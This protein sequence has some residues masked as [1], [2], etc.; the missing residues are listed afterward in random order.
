[1]GTGAS[2]GLGAAIKTT[3]V[4]GIAQAISSLPV[5]ER[6]KLAEAIDM[7]REKAMD[8]ER[9][10]SQKEAPYLHQAFELLKNTFTAT[11][12][13]ALNDMSSMTE[14]DFTAKEEAT[15]KEYTEL[16]KKSFQHHDK[17]NTGTIEKN[18]AALFLSHL[19]AE[20]GG[21]VEALASVMCVNAIKMMSKVIDDIKENPDAPEEVKV[22]LE[23]Q[24]KQATDDAKKN[25]E[26]LRDDIAKQV[27]EYKASKGDRDQ[28]AFKLMDTNGDGTLNMKE[29]LT[30]VCP[31]T[32]EN[33]KLTKA[34]GLN[35]SPEG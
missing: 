11:M 4:E 27:E 1:M 34:I 35:F 9:T 15:Q 29:F 26:K 2:G 31:G 22:E 30:Y 6:A 23:K 7:S 5:E 10:V 8:A 20:G 18:E 12:E 17:D 28:A 32:E 25:I 16:M 14:E 21:F 13:A 19:V 3:S 33:D 24:K